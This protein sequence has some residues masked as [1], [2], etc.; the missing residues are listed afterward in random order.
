MS[1]LLSWSGYGLWN[2]PPKQVWISDS[3]A[4]FAPLVL[5][6]F[7]FPAGFG[8]MEL[9]LT[10]ISGRPMMKFESGYTVETV[11]DGSKLGIEPYSVQVLPSGE[12]LILDSVNSNIYRMSSSLSLCKWVFC[13][14]LGYWLI[15]LVFMDKFPCSSDA[16][17]LSVM[18]FFYILPLPII[19]HNL[20]F[21]VTLY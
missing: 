6:C 18:F 9:S 8:L 20:S 15:A 16:F 19:S 7:F 10:V 3:T 4:T 21:P 2:P 11:F 12:L 13:N 1:C 5:F 14:D 17:V